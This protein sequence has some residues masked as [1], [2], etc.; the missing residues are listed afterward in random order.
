MAVQEFEVEE[1]KKETEQQKGWAR[2]TLMSSSDNYEGTLRF[3][4]SFFANGELYHVKT[5]HQ[6]LNSKSRVII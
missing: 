5:S 3:V 2:L 6:F 1:G 4:G